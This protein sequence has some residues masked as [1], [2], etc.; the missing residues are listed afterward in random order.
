MPVLLIFLTILMGIA[1]GWSIGAN[2]AA[3]SLGASV[4]SKVLNLKQAIL[5]IAVFGFLGAFLQGG[6]VVK[7]ISRGIVPIDQ[8]DKDLAV[9]LALV[10]CFGAARDI[11][12]CS[13]DPAL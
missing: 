1:V 2:D 10:A 13:T 8:I 5:L 3:N 11:G 9:Y 7:T 6:H 12:S 4:G